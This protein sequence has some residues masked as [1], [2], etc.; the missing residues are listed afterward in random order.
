M[1]GTKQTVKTLEGRNLAITVPKGTQPGTVLSISEQGLPT[2]GG[3]RGNIYLTIQ[4]DI[5]SV[6]KQEWVETLTKLR[7]EIN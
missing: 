4:A 7:N 6:S 1:L 5:P 3:G 2:R